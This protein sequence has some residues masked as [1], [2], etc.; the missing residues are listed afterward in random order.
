[1]KKEKKVK[2]IEDSVEIGKLVKE[3]VNKELRKKEKEKVY[4]VAAKVEVNLNKIEELA[5]VAVEEKKE[6]KKEKK[7][8]AEEE[9]VEEK[10]QEKIVSPPPEIQKEVINEK[11]KPAAAVDGGNVA[12]DELGGIVLKSKLLP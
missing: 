9:K 5:V 4:E 10:V 12:F 6:K 2:R 11:V 8:K 7:V 1:M 3:V